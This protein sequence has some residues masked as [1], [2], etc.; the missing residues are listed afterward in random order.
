MNEPTKTTQTN[1]PTDCL[2]IDTQVYSELKDLISTG[3]S[4]RLACEHCGFNK[5]KF[6]TYM[7]DGCVDFENNIDSREA[8]FY[9]A[10]REG[11]SAFVAKATKAIATAGDEGDWKAYAYLLQKVDPDNY[12]EQTHNDSAEPIVFNNDYKKETPPID[13]ET[14]ETDSQGDG[15]TEDS[16]NANDKY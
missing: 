16:D 5:A 13:N 11:R 14:T 9:L 15:D 7:A 6:A 12:G 1:L 3:M 2:G 8:R 10:V 4:P